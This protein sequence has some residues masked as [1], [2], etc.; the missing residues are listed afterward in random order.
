MPEL[1]EVEAYRQLATAAL[2][3]PVVEVIVPDDAFLRDGLTSDAL[4][5]ALVG[6]SFTAARRR[7]KLLVLD[8]DDGP[9]LGLRFG[10]TGVLEVDG[11]AGVDE[12]LYASPRRDPRW[13]RLAV[14]F[15]DGG[16][17]WL[18]DA[19]RLGS[20]QLDPDEEHLGPDAV[21]LGRAELDAAL[22]G[23]VVA[24]KARLMDQRRVAGLGNLLTDELLWRAGLDPRRPSGSLG[25]AELGRLHA[26]LG[27]TLDWALEHGGSHSGQLQPA[28]TRGGCCP[29][30]GAPLARATVGGRTTWWCPRHQR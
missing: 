29:R 15:G 1:P 26:E 3:R 22:A 28:R 30:D 21:G 9:A 7:G 20:A 13:V 24:L 5:G 17:L 18:R 23:S 10:M 8:T 2:A 12:L 25:R 4:A 19:R 6:R 27:P 11:R 14:G 16:H